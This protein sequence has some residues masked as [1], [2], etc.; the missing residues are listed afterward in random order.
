MSKIAVE[1]NI[2]K[3]E[4]KELKTAIQKELKQC[5]IQYQFK[6]LQSKLDE[7][8]IRMKDS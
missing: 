5:N 4:N 3:T 8:N 2:L 7:H 1:M 6:D